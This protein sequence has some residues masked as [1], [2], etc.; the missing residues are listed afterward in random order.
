MATRGLKVQPDSLREYE[1]LIDQFIYSYVCSYSYQHAYVM[2]L[3][4]DSFILPKKNFSVCTL[5]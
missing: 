2:Q 1:Q 3:V 5:N 4:R